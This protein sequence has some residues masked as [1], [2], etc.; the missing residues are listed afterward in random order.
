MNTKPVYIVAMC[1][2]AF[3]LW[4]VVGHPLLGHTMEEHCWQ[5]EGAGIVLGVLGTA[6]AVLTMESNSVNARCCTG[7][8]MTSCTWSS[9]I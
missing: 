3:V 2:A 5:F 6:V 1:F 9:T 4:E 7:S 8:K